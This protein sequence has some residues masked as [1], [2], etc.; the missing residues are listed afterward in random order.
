MKNFRTVPVPSVSVPPLAIVMSEGSK[1][2]TAVAP[3]V[4]AL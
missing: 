4:I 1:N 3:Q 2:G